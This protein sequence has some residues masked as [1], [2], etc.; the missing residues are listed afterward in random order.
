MSHITPRLL[1]RTAAVFVINMVVA[2]LVL[3]W[4]KWAFF[5]GHFLSD[6]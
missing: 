1:G 3:V 5:P 2:T 4:V 6:L